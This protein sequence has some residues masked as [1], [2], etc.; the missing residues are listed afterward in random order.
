M[1]GINNINDYSSTS[2]TLLSPKHKNKPIQIRRSS[3]RIK[4]RIADSSRRESGIR[5]GIS[6]TR[7]SG[8]NRIKSKGPS[9]TRRKKVNVDLY[10]DTEIKIY[11]DNDISNSSFQDDDDEQRRPRKLSSASADTMITSNLS[12]KARAKRRA[13]EYFSIVGESE[14]VKCSI[15]ERVSSFFFVSVFKNFGL[16]FKSYSFLA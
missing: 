8:S 5:G 4:S 15:C 9:Q 3:S 7:D 13:I 16:C 14:T 11:D 2:E 1:S 6:K 12:K 10:V